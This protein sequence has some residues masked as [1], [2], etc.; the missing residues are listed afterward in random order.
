[1]VC[2]IQLELK[3][4]KDDD[5]SFPKIMVLLSK[6]LT[7]YIASVHVIVFGVYPECACGIMVFQGR[8]TTHT[9]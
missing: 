5:K 8:S 6:T 3:L 1:M 2:S 9:P 4:I 7:L